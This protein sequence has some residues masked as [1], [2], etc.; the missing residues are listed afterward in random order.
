MQQGISTWYCRFSGISRTDI[1]QSASARRV[2]KINGSPRTLLYESILLTKCTTAQESSHIRFTSGVAIKSEAS[3]LLHVSINTPKEHSSAH[4][5]PSKDCFHL[6]SWGHST[7]LM[8]VMF[9]G[10]NKPNR[11]FRLHWDFLL[12]LDAARMSI[13]HRHGIPHRV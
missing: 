11:H 3:D 7:A 13:T 1:G 6:P 9:G 10:L 5:K 2:Q 4:C 12:V 8:L